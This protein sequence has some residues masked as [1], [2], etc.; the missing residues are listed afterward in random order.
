MIVTTLGEKCLNNKEYRS[1]VS[2][3]KIIWVFE[4]P[5]NICPDINTERWTLENGLA[6]RNISIIY[7]HMIFHSV[8][9]RVIPY[10]VIIKIYI[11]INLNRHYININKCKFSLG[12]S[13]GKIVLY[14]VRKYN[15]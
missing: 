15:C 8:N 13:E 1:V 2:Q 12:I 11:L 4:I 7:K 5:H 6:V 9:P 10:F 14:V 3:N